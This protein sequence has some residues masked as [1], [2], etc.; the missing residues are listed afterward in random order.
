MN[1]LQI[2]LRRADDLKEAA[3]NIRPNPLG[4][5]VDLVVATQIFRRQRFFVGEDFFERTGRHYFPSV[6]AGARPH[7]DHMIRPANRLLIMLHHQYRVPQVAQ[8][9]KCGE[10][11]LV[12]TRVQADA[13]FIENIQHTH[14]PRADLRGQANTLRLTT[15]ESAA[16]TV[17]CQI[18]QPDIPQKTE[19]R[20]DLAYHVSGDFFAKFVHLQCLE[21]RQ[22]LVDRHSADIHDR[23]ASKTELRLRLFRTTKG[24]SQH[25][26]A[27]PLTLTRSAGLGT[28]KRPKPPPRRLAARFLVQPVK[29]SQNTVER[30]GRRRLFTTA[31]ELK[32]D[33]L[34]P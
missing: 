15:T 21:K 34:L 23:Q 20:G 32:I 11:L 25:H 10:Q 14:Q 12:V 28:H 16:R 6:Q 22:R 29:V 26:F 13:R 3:G 9:I 18:A 30:L 8:S 5:H 31:G 2:I 4:R 1:V 17:E 24:H 7:V 27:K 33:R 19:P